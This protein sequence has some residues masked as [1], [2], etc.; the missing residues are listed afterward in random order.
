VNSGA[1]LKHTDI[2][3]LACQETCEIPPVEP[4]PEVPALSKIGL[5]LLAVA[6]GVA[7]SI[8]IRRGGLTVS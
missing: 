1:Q 3:A 4:A 5:S 6:I 8:I 2:D 7:G